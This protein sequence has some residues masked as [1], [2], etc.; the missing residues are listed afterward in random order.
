MGT[1][2]A[3]V[4]VLEIL[5][6]LSFFGAS[7]SAI[8]EILATAAFGFGTVTFALGVI[9]EKLGALARATKG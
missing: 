3:I 7:K 6:G 2:I 9:V 4:G 5:A 1:L 8:H